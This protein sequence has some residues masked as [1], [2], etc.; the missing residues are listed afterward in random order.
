MTAAPSS[1]PT[2]AIPQQSES[3]AKQTDRLP[4][5]KIFSLLAFLGF[6]VGLMLALF[7]AGTDATQGQVQRVF[8]VHVSAFSGATVAFFT[9]LVGGAAYLRTRSVKWD[10]LS[11]AA[12]E[13]GF[14]LSL[15]TLITGMVWARPT[16][17]TWW[18]WD[19]RLTSAAIMTL[20]YAAYFMLRGGIDNA[21]RRR[22]FAAVYSILAITTVIITF[23][24]TRIRP[25]T[26][27]PV[28]IGPSPVNA[29]GSFEM[30]TNMSATLGMNSAIWCCLVTPA[31]IWWRIR[32][33]NLTRRVEQARLN[34]LS[35]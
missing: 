34:N 20:T 12:V 15:I 35:N 19:P 22:S 27:H 24:I 8:Y 33:E 30:A 9:A 14:T 4:I 16:W 1:M 7:Y 28:V 10:T 11:L 18:T 3:S 21:D 32:L 5:L 6:F 23:M 13:V 25:D 29:K 26:I 17:N 31:L 2:N